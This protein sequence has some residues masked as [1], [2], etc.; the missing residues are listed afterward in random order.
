VHKGIARGYYIGKENAKNIFVQGTSGPH[1]MKILNSTVK[2]EMFV[3]GW[4][5]HL[6]G[7]KFLYIHKL[8]CKH[9]INGP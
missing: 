6:G 9:L 3:K 1:F 4:E 2:N 8:R 5:I 7:I